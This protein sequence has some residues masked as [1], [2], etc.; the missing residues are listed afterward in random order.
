[1]EGNVWYVVFQLKRKKIPLDQVLGD[2]AEIQ[3]WAGPFY[4]IKDS[5][6]VG[7]IQG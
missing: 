2:S 5:R 4:L 3:G 7:M 6:V 1:M